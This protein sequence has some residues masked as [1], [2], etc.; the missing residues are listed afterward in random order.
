M[1]GGADSTAAAVLL[2]Q[3]GYTVVGCTFLHL[4]SEEAEY[5]VP[6]KTMAQKLGIEHVAADL[7]ADFARDV[8]GYFT[9]GYLNGITPFPCAW[10]NIRNNFV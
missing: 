10:C 9:N 6:A 8:L 5:L 1:S 7:K 3:A 2:Q 4:P